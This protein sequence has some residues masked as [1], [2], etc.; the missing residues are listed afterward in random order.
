MIYLEIKDHSDLIGWMSKYVNLVNRT[1]SIDGISYLCDR[2]HI[3]KNLVD[4][5]SKLYKYLIG[6][7]RD[8]SGIDGT[9]SIPL[10]LVMDILCFCTFE[11][12]YPAGNYPDRETIIDRIGLAEVSRAMNFFTF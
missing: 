1:I 7:N 3:Y 10:S 8:L 12:M 6:K 11:D 9:N 5:N 2:R 4:P